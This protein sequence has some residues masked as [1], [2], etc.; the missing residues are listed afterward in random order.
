MN[1]RNALCHADADECLESRWF[2]PSVRGEH[3]DSNLGLNLADGCGLHAPLQTLH[4]RP[5]PRFVPGAEVLLA[6]SLSR[7]RFT[8]EFHIPTREGAK[9]V[10]DVR[11]HRTEV[12]HPEVGAFASRTAY[13]MMNCARSVP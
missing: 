4:L 7:H 12:S 1:R 13:S 6:A 3:F 10:L 9:R 8:L 2:I 11:T 5:S